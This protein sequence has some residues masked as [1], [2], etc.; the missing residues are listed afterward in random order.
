MNYIS[1]RG[2]IS[3]VN[4]SSAVMMGLADDGGLIVPQHIPNLAKEI[5]SWSDLNYNEIAFRVMRAFISEDDIA[6]ED[7]H[8][9]IDKSYATFETPEVTPFVKQQG[10]YIQEMFH[11]PTLAFKDVALQ[12]LGNLFEFILKRTGRKL[13]IIAATSGDTGSAAIQG[14]RGKDNIQIF[15]LHPFKKVSPLQELQMTS[16]LDENVHNIAIEGTFDDGQRIIKDLF[17]DLDF[18][19]KYDLGAVNSVNWARV[20]A[21]V[22][23]YVYGAVKLSAQNDGKQVQF[24]VPTG[25]FGNIFAGYV[26]RQLGA[27]IKTLIL[28]T[29]END[30]LSRCINSG[31]Y[32][33]GAVHQSLSPSMDIQVA[34][35]FE[36]YLYY[37]MSEN[38]DLVRES[39]HAFKAQGKLDLR[40]FLD[41]SFIAGKGD[42]E[43]TLST[44]KRYYDASG[45][46]LDPHTA[47]GVFVA[48]QLADK[49]LPVSCLATAH[50]AKFPD[51]VEQAIDS[52]VTHPSLEVL[53]G[54]ETRCAKEIA[55]RDA[56]QAYIEKTL[57]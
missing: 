30:I 26:A 34:S 39:M 17:A 35:N 46:V 1:T 16:I 36:R 20:L 18:K 53:K 51:A 50:P 49:E 24:S 47:V 42:T 54:G 37:A 2:G 28:A 29:N 12:F 23:Y 7:L 10:V 11:G 6:D 4:F 3:P 21:Q 56:I 27:P 48:E 14:V 31:V 52:H 25:N 32:E 41:G 55:N 15:V 57:A 5:C 33:L 40:E 8:T 38:P 22:V 13:N 19:G 45:Y 44:I 43:E 9:I